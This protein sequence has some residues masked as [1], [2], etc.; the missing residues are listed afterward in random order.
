MK[1]EEVYEIKEFIGKGL[2]VEVKKC[3]NC[4]ILQLFVVKEI[5]YEDVEYREKV[6][7]EF[8]VRSLLNYLFFCGVKSIELIRVVIRGMF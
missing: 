2:F 6:E 4:K 7:N 3:V 8:E 1:F 5:Y